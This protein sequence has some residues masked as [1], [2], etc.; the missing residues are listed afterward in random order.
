MKLKKK[1][2][3]TTLAASLVVGSL[4]GMPVYAASLPSEATD[5]TNTLN[6]IYAKL[7]DDKAT[8]SAA[9]DAI[10]ALED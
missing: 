2:I 6:K 8:V 3:T 9:R 10:R 5:I 1:A 4:A 7:G